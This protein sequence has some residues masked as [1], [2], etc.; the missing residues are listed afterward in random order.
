MS[1]EKPTYKDADLMLRVYELRRETVTRA[2]RDKINFGFW[3]KSYDDVKALSA[4][5]H[6]MNAAWRQVTSYWEM[7][8]GMAHQGIVHVDYWIENNGEGLFLFAKVAPY[9]TEI[10]ADG[11]PISFQHLEW[12]ATETDKGKQYFEMLQGIVKKRLASE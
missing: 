12:A 5:D 6:P 8:Y 7:V 9:L 2:A 10:R 3:P 4:F 11:S 1:S